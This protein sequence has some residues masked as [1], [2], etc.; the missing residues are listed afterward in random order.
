M[1]QKSH[2]GHDFKYLFNLLF[3]LSQLVNIFFSLAFAEGFS[4]VLGMASETDYGNPT[5]GP[6]ALFF[7]VYLLWRG[8]NY[9]IIHWFGYHAKAD[10]NYQYVPPTLLGGGLAIVLPDFRKMSPKYKARY[11]QRSKLFQTIFYLGFVAWTWAVCYYGV[12]IC[13]AITEFI[14]ITNSSSAASMG[15][16]IVVMM[17]A[18]WKLTQLYYKVFPKFFKLDVIMT[19]H[20]Q[21]VVGLRKKESE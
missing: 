1:S 12:K 14:G 11:Q 19:E 13:Y 9:K 3:A 18:E 7:P 6:V 2:Q 10:L 16:T 21:P 8:F 17:F 4:E 20:S 15:I 5:A